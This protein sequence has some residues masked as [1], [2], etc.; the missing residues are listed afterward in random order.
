VGG[1]KTREWFLFAI[2]VV[3]E[4]LHEKKRRTKRKTKGGGLN[5]AGKKKPFPI[6]KGGKGGGGLPRRG[7]VVRKK[8]QRKKPSPR[9]GVGGCTPSKEPLNFFFKKK[10]KGKKRKGKKVLG[11]EK[12]KNGF[13]LPR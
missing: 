10:G 4:P 6:V 12:L 7:K 8:N 2:W 9:P 11:K 1:A 13:F 5:L 3:K